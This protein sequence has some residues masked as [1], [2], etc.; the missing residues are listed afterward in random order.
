M[1]LLIAQRKHLDKIKRKLYV[2]MTNAG[3]SREIYL[4]DAMMKLIYS[5][6]KRENNPYIFSSLIIGK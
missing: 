2:P 6:S 1:E 4:S 3:K 5:L